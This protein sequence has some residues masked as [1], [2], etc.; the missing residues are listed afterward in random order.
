MTK[1]KCRMQL[2]GLRDPAA[3]F[4]LLVSPVVLPS[5]SGAKRW[6]LG[7]DI[8]RSLPFCMTCWVTVGWSQK[9]ESSKDHDHGPL[10]TASRRSQTMSK[11]FPSLDLQWKKKGGRT[12][13]RFPAW[14]ESLGDSDMLKSPV[15]WRANYRL[16]GWMAMLRPLS[17]S[18]HQP[19]SCQPKCEFLFQSFALNKN[20]FHGI[21]SAMKVNRQFWYLVSIKMR[22]PCPARGKWLKSVNYWM[23]SDLK[24]LT[25]QLMQPHRQN[26][27]DPFSQLVFKGTCRR[28]AGSERQWSFASESS[29]ADWTSPQW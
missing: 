5:C 16:K 27:N 15:Q 1:C 24:C 11:S 12:I 8:F 29:Y 2:R 25:F 20:L 4:L 13:L 19:V 28:Y 14:L 26:W 10:P 7:V 3:A 18:S 17:N 6:R 23:E 21:S 9:H 22:T